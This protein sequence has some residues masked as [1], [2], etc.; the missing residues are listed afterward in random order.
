MTLDVSAVWHNLKNIRLIPFAEGLRRF[1]LDLFV[2][3]ILLFAA[4]GY[5][6][7]R[8]LVNG[9]PPNRQL[10]WATCSA[11]AMVIEVGKVFFIGRVPNLDNIVLS[12]L[13]ALVGVLLI[14]PLSATPFARQ[15]GRQILLV[16]IFALI[17]YVGIVS[18]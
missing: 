11:I 8:N 3:K 18:I 7:L 16:L 10:A 12:S 2:E 9:N 15:H 14:P 6:A 17:A 5:L 13:G 1:W 4:I